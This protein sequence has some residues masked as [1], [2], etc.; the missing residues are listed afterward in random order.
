MSERKDQEL[1]I[2][3]KARDLVDETMSRTKKFDK[4]LR[5]TLSNRI[6]EK[7]L[8]VLEAIVEA[9][10]INPAI[11]TD[12]QRRAKLCMVRFDLQTSA[13][14]GCKMLL[15]F[16]DI[17]K[18]HGQIDNRACEFWT[19]RVLDVKYMT[20]AYMHW[21]WRLRSPNSGNANN[22]R[23]VN[24]DGSENNNNAYNGNVGVLPLRWIY[25]DRVARAA[26]AEAHHQRKAYPIQRKEDKHIAPTPGTTQLRGA[27]LP[28]V[29]HHYGQRLRK[30][31]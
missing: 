18:T 8:D 21:N 29:L 9:N 3:T 15:I 19:K 1:T 14:T 30:N 5:F 4:R 25:R 13:L 6:D 17:A 2:I 11:E 7:A 28:A 12:P 20:A 31:M 10:E 22:V 26:K 16:L 23:N 27:G 24:S